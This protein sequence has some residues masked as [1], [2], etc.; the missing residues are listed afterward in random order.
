MIGSVSD[1]PQRCYTCSEHT[2]DAHAP[3]CD[4]MWETYDP[5]GAVAV[6][7]TTLPSRE[8]DA[9]VRHA[10]FLFVRATCLAVLG[11]R[12]EHLRPS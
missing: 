8:A 12:S 3:M 4:G 1:I 6:I 9:A 5:V 11:G 7:S 2:F 10:L